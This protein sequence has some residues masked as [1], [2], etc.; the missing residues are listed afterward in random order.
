MEV[1]VEVITALL[2]Y[3][4]PLFTSHQGKGNQSG[5]SRAAIAKGQAVCVCYVGLFGEKTQ[6]FSHFIIKD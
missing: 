4:V 2:S 5:K 1:K 3:R 6:N